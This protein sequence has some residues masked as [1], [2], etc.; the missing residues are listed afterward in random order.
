MAKVLWGAGSL[1]RDSVLLIIAS[2]R[3]Q[4]LERCLNKVVLYH[5][6]SGNV[7]VVVSEDGKNTRVRVVV[8]DARA[9]LLLHDPQAQMIH[10]NHDHQQSSNGYYALANHFKWALSSVF[11]N[12]DGILSTVPQRVIIL[13]EDLEIAPDF[14][15]FFAATAPIVESDASVLTASAWNDNGQIRNVRDVEQVYRSD[16][17]PGLGWLMTARLWAELKPK[18]PQAYWDD[19]LR[20]PKN[21]LGRH[22]LRPEVCRTLHYGRI[23][24]GNAQYQNTMADILLNT[25]PVNFPAL[26]L[27]YLQPQAW[28]KYYVEEHVKKAMHTTPEALDRARVRDKSNTKGVDLPLKPVPLP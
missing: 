28:E 27:S 23:G 3:P 24:V 4:Y 1:G 18:W 9:K 22:T 16:F 14:F 15:S 17:F 19:W 2:N 11:D 13:E 5:P 8:N 10:L 6:G 26:D 20:E 21:R 25:Q 7:P 12:Q